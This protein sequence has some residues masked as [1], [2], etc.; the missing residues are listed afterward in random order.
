VNG[1]PNQREVDY[2]CNLQCAGDIRRDFTAYCEANPRFADWR[3]AW[4]AFMAQRP[5]EKWVSFGIVQPSA[6]PRWKQRMRGT[7]SRIARMIMSPAATSPSGL[8]A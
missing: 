3:Q 8:V 4:A 2:Q 1:G 6:I 5:A 7:V